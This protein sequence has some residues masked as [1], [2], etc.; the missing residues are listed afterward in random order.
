MATYWRG[1][2]EAGN[3]SFGGVGYF[4]VGFVNTRIGIRKKCIHHVRLQTKRNNVRSVKS[5]IAG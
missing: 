3:Y 2:N 4:N 5:H 1:G